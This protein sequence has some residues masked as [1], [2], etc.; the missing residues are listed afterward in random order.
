LRALKKLDWTRCTDR[1]SEHCVMKWTETVLQVNYQLFKEG[2][3]MVSSLTVS[4][5]CIFFIGTSHMDISSFC[6]PTI[7]CFWFA[8]CPLSFQKVN[9]IPNCGLLTN[10]LGM[11]MSLRQYEYACQNSSSGAKRK[12]I[13]MKDFVPETYCIDDARDRVQFLSILRDGQVWIYKPS[14]MNQ[15]KGIQLIR[16]K[17]DFEKLQEDCV[18]EWRRNPGS[19]RPRILQR[20][21]DQPLLLE[22]RKFDIRCYLLIASSMPFLVLFHP[23]Y[24]RVC[25]R[26]Y[27]VTSP[28]L[29]VHLTNQEKMQNIA[30]HCFLMVKEK[31]ASR[32]GLFEI[33]G[34]DFLVDS[35]MNVRVAAA[36]TA[37]DDDD[38]DDDDD[39]EDDNEEDGIHD[40]YDDDDDD[41]GDDDEDDD[42]DDDEDVDDNNNNDD[43]DDDDDDEDDDDDDDDDDDRTN[44]RRPTMHVWAVFLIEINTNPAMSTNCD[45]LRQVIPPIVSDFIGMP[46]YQ[47]CN[48]I[49]I[50]FL[51]IYIVAAFELL[52]VCQLYRR[53]QQVHLFQMDKPWIATRNST[54]MLFLPFLVDISIECFEKARRWKPLLPLQGITPLLCGYT[55][56][57]TSQ[58]S[59]VVSLNPLLNDEVVIN[60]G[61]PPSFTVLYYET[62]DMAK[63][64]KAASNEV[65]LR[66]WTSPHYP[67]LDN[68]E[69]AKHKGESE[70]TNV[71]NLVSALPN[72]PAKL[73]PAKFPGQMTSVKPVHSPSSSSQ[74]PK[75]KVLTHGPSKDYPGRV[76]LESKVP[77]SRSSP[78]AATRT[79]LNGIM[80]KS[81]NVNCSLMST[82]LDNLEPVYTAE[83]SQGAFLV[84]E[85]NEE[86]GNRSRQSLSNNSAETEKGSDRRYGVPNYISLRCRNLANR[87]LAPIAKIEVIST[88]I[89]GQRLRHATQVAGSLASS[90]S[91]M[92]R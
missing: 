90:S 84:G 12:Y 45:V 43:D 3:I 88:K 48:Q 32:V 38:V 77:H 35:H 36:A 68:G 53:W 69:N 23:G 85:D 18:E 16:G 29:L 27:D 65:P 9:H 80:P 76:R 8:F 66:L 82:L 10:K 22:G 2:E 30:Q 26:K 47:L 31:L 6:H 73:L 60:Y 70:K 81:T 28:D 37:D 13:P 58:R 41:G 83:L 24:V 56:S 19:I 39:D 54:V 34:M 7:Y 71:V 49:I 75:P 72:N 79:P 78:L 21:I 55:E 92:C 17:A 51:E 40:E 44:S 33:Y 11:L 50:H 89:P 4:L 15:G 14:G 91:T 5:I 57:Q 20:Y 63:S 42:D 46:N 62:L 67:R 87:I 64:R 25:T 61:L 52:T 86:D 1:S 59:W 74:P